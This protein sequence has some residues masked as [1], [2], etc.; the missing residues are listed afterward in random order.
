VKW[1]AACID[2]HIWDLTHL[3]PFCFSLELPARGE[4]HAVAFEIDV[5]F[6]L[7]CFTEEIK[8][9]DKAELRYADLREIR[10]FNVERYEL[11]FLLPDIIRSLDRRRCYHGRFNNFMTFEVI[12]N[13]MVR[14]YQI[15]F[16]VSR[17]KQNEGRLSLFVQSAYP[18][19]VPQKIQREKPCLFKT[20][21]VQAATKATKK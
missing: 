21:C 4:L 3:H 1:R 14:H 18:K 20:I 16:Q 7:H 9:G 17:S 19:S 11:S 8:E 2:G 10:S 6:G 13:G 5:V 15:Y 12:R